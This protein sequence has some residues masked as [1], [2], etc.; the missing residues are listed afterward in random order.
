MRLRP[1]SLECSAMDESRDHDPAARHVA[2]HRPT[3]L[4]WQRLRLG[5]VADLAYGFLGWFRGRGSGPED[6]DVA[7]GRIQSLVE[8]HGA[9]GIDHHGRA[10]K[11]ALASFAISQVF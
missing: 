6:I 5:L 8:Q 10:A 2:L 3:E 11:V 1:E 7:V 4:E 9:A